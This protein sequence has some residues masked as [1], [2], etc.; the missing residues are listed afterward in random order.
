MRKSSA[1]ALLRCPVLTMSEEIDR[2]WH[3]RYELLRGTGSSLASLHGAGV[4]HRP[5][6][7]VLLLY[8]VNEDT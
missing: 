2:G 4:V 8:C 1:R 3:L 7:V 5:A 6:G